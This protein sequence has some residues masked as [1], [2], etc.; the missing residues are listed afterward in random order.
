MY[1]G[2]FGICLPLMELHY[3]FAKNRLQQKN[4]FLLNTALFCN[5]FVDLFFMTISKYLDFIIISLW[6]NLNAGHSPK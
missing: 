6:I 1:Q 3:M 5:G 4:E 2:Y